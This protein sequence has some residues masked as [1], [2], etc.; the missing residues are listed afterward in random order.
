MYMNYEASRWLTYHA[1]WLRDQGERADAENAAAKFWA[2]EAAVGCARKLIDIYGAWGNAVEHIPQ[3]LLRDSL[4]LISA[5]GTS[6]IMRLVM[7]RTVLRRF[8]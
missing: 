2:T 8:V 1:A 5:A 7:T 4:P 6:E 3:R